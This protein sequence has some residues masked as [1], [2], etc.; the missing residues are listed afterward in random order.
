[1]YTPACELVIGLKVSIEVATVSA[2]NWGT[3][4]IPFPLESILPEGPV[5]WICGVSLM[6]P[7]TWTT[8]V[9]VMVKFCPALSPP[10]AV[11]VTTRAAG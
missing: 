4:S 10:E 11:T 8:A 6:R 9:Q 2:V 3:N 7:S 1:M 5:H